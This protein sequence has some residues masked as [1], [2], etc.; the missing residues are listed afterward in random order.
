MARQFS[1]ALIICIIMWC[2]ASDKPVDNVIIGP[3]SEN[4]MITS[5]E[6]RDHID[7]SHLMA[8]VAEDDPAIYVSKGFEEQV[9]TLTAAR[10]EG[11]VW[12]LK[13][14][15]G[16]GREKKELKPEDYYPRVSIVKWTYLQGFRC[17]EKEAG[18]W[19]NVLNK[20]GRFVRSYKTTEKA[21]WCM[22]GD[23]S[24]K[25]IL[26]EVTG[27]FWSRREG[28]GRKRTETRKLS[29]CVP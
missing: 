14:D 5:A 26:K 28:R 1:I 9:A 4:A 13:E 29:A 2:C 20:K 12:F 11:Q 23:G 10:I 7:A 3:V 24:C 22:S 15:N 21:S 17:E 19:I 8:Y 25:I 16:Q 6:A 18:T 27:E